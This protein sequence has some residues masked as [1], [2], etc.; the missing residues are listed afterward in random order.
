ME[1][2][3]YARSAIRHWLLIAT[4]GLAAAV[5][6]FSV[7]A[8][9]PAN[10][11]SNSRF[12]IGPASTLAEGRDIAGAIDTLGKRSIA[13]T[14]AELVTSEDLK[15]SAV[16]TLKLRGSDDY[17]ISAVI[18]PD[19]YVVKVSGTGPDASA[20]AAVISSVTS[21]AVRKFEQ[22]YPVYAINRLDAVRPATAPFEPRPERDAALGSF[23]GAATGFILGLGRDALKRSRFN[24]SADGNAL[25]SGD[26]ILRPRGRAGVAESSAGLGT[27]PL[28][29]AEEPAGPVMPAARTGTE[30]TGTY[31]APLTAR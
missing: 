31:E 8:E 6:S 11:R 18:L 22:L 26:Q 13:G 30:G 27:T 21:Q 4:M 14:F 25:Q 20:I 16:R 12:V 17:S 9:Q 24:A 23:I 5:L 28:P 3:E 15:R 2:S 10:Y 29:I 7:A 19:A 1:L